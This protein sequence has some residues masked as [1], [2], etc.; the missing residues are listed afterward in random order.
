MTSLNTSRL[1]ERLALVCA[2]A[3][4]PARAAWSAASF[5]ASW[6]C[7]IA[8]SQLRGGLVEASWD[9][10]GGVLVGRQRD[11]VAELVYRG[12]LHEDIFA[13]D[14]APCGAG[15]RPT[16]DETQQCDVPEERFRYRERLMTYQHFPPHGLLL[17]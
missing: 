6:A 3:F 9:E 12:I 17:G 14:T 8:L 10:D 4:R 15:R 16:N 11:S 1:S 5:S 2:I 7:S 13:R